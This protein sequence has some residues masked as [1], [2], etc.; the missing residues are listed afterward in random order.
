MDAGGP[1]GDGKTEH[2]ELNVDRQSIARLYNLAGSLESANLCCKIN[3]VPLG[4]KVS[5]N[6]KFGPCLPNYVHRLGKLEMFFGRFI[7]DKRA[8]DQQ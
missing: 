3:I 8:F 1:D 4:I 5:Q 7:A 2:E 6:A